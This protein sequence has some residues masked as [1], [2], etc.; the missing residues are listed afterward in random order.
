MQITKKPRQLYWTAHSK[1]KMR[2]YGLSPARVKRILHS[3]ARIER[4]IAPDTIAYMQRAGSKKH[5]YE[6][7]TMVEDQKELRK[8][9][10]AWRYP[11]TTKKGEPLPPE[12]LRELA[13]LT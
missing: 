5:Q 13:E 4:G 8:V 7:W 6:L 11:G 1:T 12:I 10:S 9:I 3:P 2:F